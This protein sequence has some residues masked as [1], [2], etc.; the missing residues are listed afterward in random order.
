MDRHLVAVEVSV[1]RCTNQRVKLDRLAFHQDGLK[2]LNAQSVQCRSTVQHYRMLFDD[3]FQNIPDLRVYALNQFLGVLDILGNISLLQFL[4][5]EGLEEL[6][7]HFL[8]H[9]ALIDLQ[10]GTD[11]DNASSGVVNTLAQEVLSETASLTFKHVGQGLE[12]PVAGTCDRTAASAV[13]DQRVDRFLKHSLL[14]PDDDV[15][16]AEFKKSLKTIVSVDDPSV[17]IIQVG[18]CESSAVELHHGAQ[19]RRNDRDAVHDHPGRRIS[20][21]AEGLDDFQSLDDPGSLLALHSLHLLAQFLVFF[22]YLDI[23]KQL[24]DSL[25]THSR[26]E[27]VAVLLSGFL[28]LALSQ[29]LLVLE[30]CLAFVQYDIGGKIEHS[31]KDLR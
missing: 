25:G 17:Q 26:A 23:E 9:A 14:V 6:Q 19:I 29:H 5:N 30:V 22:L 24:F 8:R 3:I 28:I 12:G 1:E 7:R 18:S 27:L 20:G 4:H 15:R 21:L 10:F 11:N 2:R 13:V 31:L 16:S